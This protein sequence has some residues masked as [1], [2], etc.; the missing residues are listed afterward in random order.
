MRKLSLLCGLAAVFCVMALAE[1]WTGKLM[2]APCYDQHKTAKQC[3]ATTSTTSFVFEVGGKI[4]KLD[5]AGNTKAAEAIRNRAE[6][7]EN[8]NHPSTGSV[9]AKVS[10]VREGDEIKVDMIEVQ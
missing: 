6:R 1:N 8:P 7:A 3:D 4:Y 10:G 2:D 5:A 9:N